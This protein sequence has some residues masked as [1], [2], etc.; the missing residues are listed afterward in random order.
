MTLI[1]PDN[2]SE[3]HIQAQSELEEHFYGAATVFQDAVKKLKRGELVNP[4]DA[5]D[6]GRDYFKVATLFFE[7][8]NR[9]A[10]S[11]RKELGIVHDYAID[12][13]AAREEIRCRMA[14]LRG[15]AGG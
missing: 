15:G 9:L 12:F 10:K 1:K 11:R 13:D 4:N 3:A 7:E 6:L 2:G 8:A 5:K 14:C